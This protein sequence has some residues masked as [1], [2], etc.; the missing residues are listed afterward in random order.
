MDDA[1]HARAHGQAQPNA[2]HGKQGEPRALDAFVRL[3]GLPDDAVG[4][5]VFVEHPTKPW[6]G[7]KPDALLGSNAVLEIK[8][9]WATRND[10][11]HP[12]ELATRHLLQVWL[13]LE[14]TG[15]AFAYVVAYSGGGAHLHLWKVKRDQRRF[16]ARWMVS[17]TLDAQ[18]DTTSRT[19]D[20]ARTLWEVCA[21][22]F[23][24]YRDAVLDGNRV[25]PISGGIKVVDQTRI[26]REIAAYRMHAVH[27]LISVRPVGRAG[28]SRAPSAP[29]TRA[30]THADRV[31]N[32]FQN[33]TLHETPDPVPHR[34]RYHACTDRLRQVLEAGRW[35]A[36]RKRRRHPRRVLRRHHDAAPRRFCGKPP[37]GHLRRR[38]AGRAIQK[39]LK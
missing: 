2:E 9:P 25:H 29:T 27:R 32:P 22:E 10:P 33:L 37:V 7:A 17:E 11:D 21:S 1:A 3:A 34:P 4:H 15:R 23:D 18:L 36:A 28:R 5:P 26:R 16:H 13:Q 35:S 30:R 8:T 6:L 38:A 12:V 39:G 19:F 24:K 20:R 31:S 14:C